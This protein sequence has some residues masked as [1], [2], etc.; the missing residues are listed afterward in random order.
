[1]KEEY[2]NKQVYFEYNNCPKYHLEEY[3]DELFDDDNSYRERY[4]NIQD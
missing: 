3:E 4:D 2:I 1:M